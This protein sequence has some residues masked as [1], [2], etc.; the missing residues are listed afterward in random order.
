MDA[1]SAPRKEFGTNMQGMNTLPHISRLALA[2]ALLIPTAA[3][4]SE[5]TPEQM[6]WYRAQM[7]LASTSGPPPSTNSVGDAVMEW[8]RLTANSSASFDQLSRFLMTNKGWPDADKMQVR[9]EKAI[10]IDSFDPAR[11]LA[12]FKAYPPQTASGH[13]RQALAL[14]ASGRRDDA[15]AAVRRAWVSG[16]LD[17]AETVSYT[18][19]TLPT[20]DLV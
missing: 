6:A 19:L 3:T 2:M 11:T 20:S 7:G 13:L 10:A 17:D 15:N 9:A 14:N 4:A 18:H 16:P 12:Y 5:L 1:Y 8:R